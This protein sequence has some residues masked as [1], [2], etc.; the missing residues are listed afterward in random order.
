MDLRE[1]ALFWFGKSA[2]AALFI[3]MPC[4]WSPHSYAQIGVLWLTCELV[5]G[6][7]LAFLFQVPFLLFP[8]SS[9]G[10]FTHTTDEWINLLASDE[11][12]VAHVVHDVGF[13]ERDAKGQISTPW[14]VS[15]LCTTA[16][17]SHGSWFWL[18]LSGG[19][20]YQVKASLPFHWKI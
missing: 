15:Q 9:L 10:L 17:F 16:D 6:Y 20:N 11:E 13:F 7:M 12:K 19:L 8:L 5:T 2:Y 3:A 14:A 4:L 1:H 18:H